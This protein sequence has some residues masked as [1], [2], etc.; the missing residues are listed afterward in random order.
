M[1]GGMDAPRITEALEAFN[2]R[3]FLSARDIYQEFLE[4]AVSLTGAVVGYFHLYDEEHRELEL[5]V[6]SRAVLDNCRTIHVGHYPLRDAG[7]WADS[8]RRRKTVIHNDYPEEAS[9]AGL[10]EGHFPV[11]RHMSTPVVDRSGRVVAVVGVGNSPEPFGD[12]SRM[13]LERVIF[14]GWPVVEARLDE[15]RARRSTRRASY[16]LKSPEEVLLAMV[17]ALS[18]AIEMRDDYTIDHEENVARIADA[19]AVERGLD[20]DQRLGLRLGATLHDIGKIAIPMGILSKPGELSPV[21]YEL[22][23]THAER[24]AEI[25]DGL[26][27]PWPIQDMIRQHHE[28]MNGSGYPYGLKDGEICV[29]AR[30][31]A[32]ADVYDAMVS[33]RPYRKALGQEAALKVLREGQGL[34]FDPYVVNALI[35]CLENDRIKLA[36]TPSFTAGI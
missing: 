1:D 12:D 11:D 34:L 17:G 26:E 18:R 33:D 24:G 9:V 15:L 10:P 32:V 16:G 36:E 30:I 25:F 5:A 29:E 6:W 8:I 4:I 14:L 28:R 35:T 27:F 20:D 21:E 31:I 19:I 2:A 23:K 22:V 3:R 7:I 13:T